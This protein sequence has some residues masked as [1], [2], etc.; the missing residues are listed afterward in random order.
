[1]KDDDLTQ[2]TATLDKGQAETIVLYTTNM[3]DQVAPSI[4]AETA[5]SPRGSMRAPTSSP[6]AEGHEGG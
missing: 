5:S 1:M 4:K 2:L 6:A 3:A